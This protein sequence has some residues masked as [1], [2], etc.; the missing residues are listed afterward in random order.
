MNIMLLS[1]SVWSGNVTD[2][3]PE[4]R[5]FFHWAL[6]ADR[7][8]GRRLCGTAVLCERMARAR[9]RA[10]N[11]DVPIS[12]GVMLAL[13]CRWY[14]TAQPCR[15]RLFRFRRDAAVLPAVRPRARSRHAPQDAR[16]GRQPGGAEGRYRAPLRPAASWCSVPAAALKAGRPGAGAA[17]RAGAGRRRRAQRRSEIDESLITGE[18][19]R[20]KVAPARR[21]MPAA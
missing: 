19:A 17:G 1:V 15:A 6:G 12:L 5:D 3:T 10:L 14:E 13:A 9:S 4:T 18:T 21:F 7:A 11:M 20:R 16:G 2:I 8:A